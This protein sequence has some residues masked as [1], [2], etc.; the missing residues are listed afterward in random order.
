MHYPKWQPDAVRRLT[1]AAL[2]GGVHASEDPALIG[3]RQLSFGRNVYWKNGTLRVRPGVVCDPDS[4]RLVSSPDQQA[5]LCTTVTCATGCSY[6]TGGVR[7]EFVAS[8]RRLEGTVGGSGAEV[9]ISLL[10]ETGERID[11]DPIYLNDDEGSYAHT[12]VL[13]A[14]GNTG[15]RGEGVFAYFEGG[16][17]YE[18]VEQYRPASQGGIR[19]YWL[20]V[21]DRVTVPVVLTAGRGYASHT[22][23]PAEASG[24]RIGAFNA[25]T[26]RF[27]AEYTTDDAANAFVLPLSRTPAEIVSVAYT[28][29]SGVE[30]V[31]AINGLTGYLTIDGVALVMRTSGNTIRFLNDG[32]DFPLPAAGIT[33]NLRVTARYATDENVPEHHIGAM[34]TAVWFG[35]TGG[36]LYGGSRLFVAGDADHPNKLCWSA[37]NDP[38]YFPVNNYAA[39]GDAGEA[40][41]AFGRQS[42][43]LVIFKE[44]SIFGTVYNATEV[45]A[46]AVAA[47]Q[48]VDLEAAV[49]FPIRPIHATVG[50]DCPHSVALCAN[51]LVWA[52]GDR[53][54]YTLTGVS[55]FSE[56]NVR[57]IAAPIRPVWHPSA[58]A[59]REA[60]A[61]DRSG[62]YLLAAGGTA[63][64]L[65]YGDAAPDGSEWYYWD[66]PAEGIAAKRILVDGET[67]VVFA[68]KRVPQAN[69]EDAAYWLTLRV[70]GGTDALPT[71]DL[72]FPALP[73]TG[74]LRTKLFDFGEAQRYHRILRVYPHTSGAVTFGWLTDRGEVTACDKSAVPVPAVPHTVRF[75]AAMY[76][77]A[78]SAV[79]GLTVT[80]RAVGNRKG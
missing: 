8:I 78:D 33:N 63:V 19:R 15:I 34:Q 57:E 5:E 4:V 17:V 16:H 71:N 9:L 36:G 55:A 47:G 7:G 41:T 75:G 37:L 50:C 1:V 80:A 31:Y 67:P 51:R 60:V 23:S 70:G 48:V 62:Y 14:R 27:I 12:T 53:R 38:L 79:A 74:E 58:A 11:T 2:N 3:D 32:A 35:G 40:I 76:L 66:F 77:G 42:D 29:A 73:V 44:H 26:D 43:T 20:P 59:L 56:R 28:N 25:L 39:I 10:A 30:T 22:G 46:A 49:L 52:T 21:T 65:H 24:T 64:A 68:E 69:D 72:L 61:A 6:F 45:D 13:L 54:V 18:Y